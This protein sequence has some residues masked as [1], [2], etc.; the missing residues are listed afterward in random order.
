M[1]LF[2]TA[3]ASLALLSIS[4]KKEAK[5]EAPE[6]VEETKANEVTYQV[7]ATGS[8]AY[9]TGYKFTNKTAVKG[10]FKKIEVKSAPVATSQIE[11][12]NNVE[13]AIPTSSVFSDNEVRD[14]K[15]KTLFF[16]IMDMTEFI[17]GTFKTQGNEILVDLKLNNVTKTIPLTSKISDRH[18]KLNGTINIMDFGAEKA[19][20]SIHK[21]CEILHTGEDGVSKTWEEFGIE[22]I[23]YLK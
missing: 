16:D 13:F 12:F 22:A 18:V 6:K 23:V 4:C 21:A 9:W 15:L 19:F 14:N 20:N 1:K 17:T 5:K 10:K 11:A 8:E 3:L 2:I 7:N